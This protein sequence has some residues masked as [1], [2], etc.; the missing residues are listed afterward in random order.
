MGSLSLHTGST[1]NIQR[2][3]EK[4]L[5]EQLQYLQ[6]NSPYYSRLFKANHIQIADVTSLAD[7]KKL[8]VTTKSDLQQFNTDFLCV[9]TTLVADYVTTSGTLGNP[10]TFAL[11]EKDLNRL[12]YN[13]A[14]ALA[15][16]GCTANDTIQLALT[17]DKRFVAGLAY[18]L[19]ARHLGAT[20]IRVG[21][22]EPELQWDSVMRFSPTVLIT[23]PSFLLMLI[24]Y[25]KAKGIDYKNSSVQRV[26]CIGEPVRNADFSLNTLGS[27]IAAEWDIPL[28]ATYASTEMS[29]AFTECEALLGGHE[30]PELIITELLDENN[31]PVAANQPGEVTITTLGVEGMPLL[32][33]KTGDICY[34][35]TAPC[36]CGRH[37][38]RLGPI[39]GRKQQM[40]KYKGTTLYPQSIFNALQG[41]QGI[42]NYV[43]EVFTNELGTD[44]LTLK[45][46]VYN[47]TMT[48]PEI[49]EYFKSTLRVTPYIQLMQPEEVAH[50]Q[51]LFNSRKPVKF[52]DN[53]Q[54][55]K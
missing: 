29:T 54:K 42:E 37:T 17:L 16:A 40:I 45:L 52:I 13:E 35:Y 22:G 27:A 21:A 55:Q 20:T 28:H 3:Q 6:Q 23:V 53:R 9:P 43:V 44:E 34:A 7:L 4:A 36:T 2:F 48:E 33:F 8:P 12:A 50:L 11:T 49:R 38:Q 19:G 25:A 30:I 15:T 10:V 31:Q 41:L 1:N 5:A 46:G 14:T 24:K 26:I 39:L 18:Y 51:A 32:R 47:G